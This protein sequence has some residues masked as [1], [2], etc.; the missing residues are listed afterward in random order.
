MTACFLRLPRA[1]APWL[2]ACSLVLGGLTAN[3]GAQEQ[4][5][6][7]ATYASERPSEEL[8]KMEPFRQRLEQGLQAAGYPTAKVEM[9]IYATYEEAV[10]TVSRDQADI[11]RLGPASYVLAKRANPRL[12]ILAMEREEG[13][14]FLSGYIFVPKNSPIKTLADLKG[15]TFAFGENN[16][17]T[18]RYLPQAALVK[19]GLL[20]KDLASYDYLGRHDKV[21][22]AVA[23]GA[24]DA[25]SANE[26]TMRKYGASK[27]LRAIH[28]LHSPSHAWVA[29]AGLDPALLARLRAILLDIRGD[30]LRLISRDGFLTAKDS[31]YDALRAAMKTAEAF[32]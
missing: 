28:T 9:R 21:I 15:K 5:L 1:L 20:G 25:G 22:Y 11:A 13:T 30:E 19:A 2:W 18:G 12:E 32:E 24:Y 8:R 3:A 31:D 23:S 14:R 7:F 17:T 29:R 6:L 10:T 26:V 4:T 16:S 27:G